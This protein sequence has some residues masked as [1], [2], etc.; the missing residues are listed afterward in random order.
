MTKKTYTIELTHDD[1]SLI[2]GALNTHA[3]HFDNLIIN[4]PGASE[5]TKLVWTNAAKKRRA[6]TKR[7]I[8]E[9][10]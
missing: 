2:G 7:I 3:N 1:I 9:G 10:K 4:K 6:L 5:Q 8:D